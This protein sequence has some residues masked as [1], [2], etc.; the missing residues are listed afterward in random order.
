L[1]ILLA[2]LSLIATLYF[3]MATLRI[4]RRQRPRELLL[5]YLGLFSWSM[6][7]DILSYANLSGHATIHNWEHLCVIGCLVAGCAF[8]IRGISLKGGGEPAGKRH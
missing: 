4:W 3:T 8:E 6:A 2:A 5:R 1:W 7:T